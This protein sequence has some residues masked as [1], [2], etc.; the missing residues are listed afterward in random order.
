MVIFFLIFFTFSGL[1]AM[2]ITWRLYSKAAFR[3]RWKIAMALGIVVTMF[4][5]VLT[6]S[7]PSPCLGWIFGGGFFEFCIFLCRYSRPG[8]DVLCRI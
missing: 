3:S 4:M 6:T 1:L 8:V 5:P 7:R 2:Y